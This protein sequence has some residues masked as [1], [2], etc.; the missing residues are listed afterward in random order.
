M[1]KTWKI[2]NT[3]IQGQTVLA[4]LA[5]VGDAPFRVICREYG[6]SLIYTEFISAQGLLHKNR[7]TFKMIELDR[8]EHPVGI[9]LFGSVPAHL[10]EASKFIEDAGADFVDLNCGCPE[11][12]I[13]SNGSGAALLKDPDLIARIV[14][15]M[16]KAVSIPVTLK[17]RIGYK[18]GYP[19]YKE[20]GKLAQEAGAK[21]ISINCCYYGVR[22]NEGFDWSVVS[23]L[24]EILDIPVIGNGGIKTGQDAKKVLEYGADAV[25]IGRA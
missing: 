25:M 1:K 17:I 2:G 3:E 10:A 11:R 14:E 19:V 22:P 7:K 15:A 18:K 13:V 20:V 16:V 12:K 5:G 21:A 8:R 4:P 23:D 24:K 6:C 9:Q